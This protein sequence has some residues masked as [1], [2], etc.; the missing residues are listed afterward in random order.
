V[1]RRAIEKGAT[2]KSRAAERD[3][4]QA[5]VDQAI[6]AFLPRVKLS[7]TYR[8]VSPVEIPLG[9]AAIVG[10]KN[11]GGLYV[12]PTLPNG[13]TVILD[14]QQQ[15]VGA[16][17]FTIQGIENQYELKAELGIPI[18]DL[19]F[20]MNRTVGAAKSA[21]KATEL[22][23]STERQKTALDATI[24]YYNFLRAESSLR[25]S[26]RSLERSK[27][28][29]EDAKAT[30]RAGV[31]TKVDALRVDALVAST[32]VAV[33]EAQRMVSLTRR[34]LQ[35]I[36]ADDKLEPRAG[37]EGITDSSLAVLPTVE[38]ATR[39]ALT[40]R[41]ELKALRVAVESVD[42]KQ[43]SSQV[44]RYPR[45]D[46]F[47]QV[48]NG[49]P[50]NAISIPVDQWKTT[51]AVGVTLSY[52]PN[53][54]INNGAVVAETRAERERLSSE[55]EN[56]ERNVKLQTASAVYELSKAQ[57][58]IDAAKR[59][60]QAASDANEAA[61]ALYRAGEATTTDLL[62]AETRLLSAELQ[63]VYA[64][65]DLATA[66]SRLDYAVGNDLTSQ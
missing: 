51:W 40:N 60:Q 49:R 11:E 7:A 14:D 35:V 48:M 3:A 65:L 34:Q 50:N 9:D 61:K 62:D 39:G 59:G 33:A 42:K 32:E 23:E 13:R 29:L 16:K 52:S 37:D 4:A 56:A 6:A 19:I 20:R 10:A 38:D 55:L 44:A 2:V 27:A 41:G 64:R 63:L 24:A 15:P 5:R 36:L 25:V 30:T 45:L 57:T 46:G 1:V 43:S 58:V 31:T 54:T 28:L 18:S 12:G 53:D 47:G 17:R 8:R 21:T 66:Q 22:L 26:Q